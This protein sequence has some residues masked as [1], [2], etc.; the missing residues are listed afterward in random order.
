MTDRS[1][2]IK[3]IL[4]TVKLL[5]A[6]Y[7][8][9]TGKPLGVTGEVAEYV[10]AEK[11][12]LELTPARTSG[13]DAIRKTEKG[14]VRIQIKGRAFGK[15]SKPSQRLGRIKE[16]ADCDTVLLVVLDNTTLEPVGMWEAGYDSVI[17][18]LKEPGSKARN[19]RGALSVGDFKRLATHI[20]PPTVR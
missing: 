6:E 15:E 3:Q 19:E 5:A 10:A 1:E 14:N 9:L 11:L 20:W 18:R 7:Y 17:A 2:R 12:N 16:K 13:H 4:A 8:Q